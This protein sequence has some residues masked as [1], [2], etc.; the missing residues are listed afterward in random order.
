MKQSSSCAGAACRRAG[1]DVCYRNSVGWEKASALQGEGVDMLSSLD[2]AALWD[3][4]LMQKTDGMALGSKDL[5]RA[6]ALPAA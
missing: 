3:S 1:M 6:V 5:V 2:D 4:E